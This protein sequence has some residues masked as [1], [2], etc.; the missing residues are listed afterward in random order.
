[1]AEDG[2]DGEDHPG[3]VAVSVADENTGR[4]AVVPPE[5]EGDAD[6]GEEEV[7]GEEMG[8]CCW[9][10]VVGEEVEAVVHGEEAGDDEGLGDF[11]AVY[12]GEDVD[13]VWGED[14]DA[15]H[16]DVVQPAEVEEVA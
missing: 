11:Y 5:G 14:G 10:G 8:V 9:V 6:E 1:M 15:G 3:E 2:D 7:E 4:V 12:A 16:V 13:G